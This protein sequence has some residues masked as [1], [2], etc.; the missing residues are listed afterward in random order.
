MPLLPIPI[1]TRI[2]S[3][4]D[5][6][7]FCLQSLLWAGLLSGLTRGEATSGDPLVKTEQPLMLG[8]P[9]ATTVHISTT[10]TIT[11]TITYKPT[12]APG[13]GTYTLLGCYGEPST[14]HIFN[15]DGSCKTPDGIAEQKLTIEDCLKGC[16]ASKP[17]EKD[18]A[19]YAYAGTKNGR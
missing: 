4:F 12:L 5:A 16:A 13:D 10:R 19:Q 6:K 2:A 3:D 15:E 14:G 9:T 11:I 1:P 18:L 7:R 8:S 17:P